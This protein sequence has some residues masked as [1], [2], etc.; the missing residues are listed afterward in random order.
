MRILQNKIVMSKVNNKR[1]ENQSYSYTKLWKSIKK[2]EIN[3]VLILPGKHQILFEATDGLYGNSVIEMDD[4]L[5][6]NMIEHN[7]DINYNFDDGIDYVNFIPAILPLAFFLIVMRMLP[8]NNVLPQQNEKKKIEI[9]KETNVKFENVAGIDEA[10]SEIVE[11]VDFLKDP[12]KYE[13]AGAVIP[14]GCLI[15]GPPGTG[16]TL[17]AKAIAGEANVPFISSSASEFVEIF[18]GMG[19]LRIRE[20]FIKARKNAPCIVFIDEIDAIGKSRSLNPATSNDEREQTLNQLL[21]EMDGFENNSGVIIIAATNRDE[22]LDKALVRPGRFDRKINISLPTKSGRLEI[23]NI[24]SKNKKVKQTDLEILA[25][26]TIGFS[27]AELMN[28]MN[29]SSI[30]AAR[31]N[32]INITKNDIDEAYDKVTLGLK[33]PHILSKRRKEMIAY[34][35]AGHALLALLCENYD[36]VER[37]TIIPR[38]NA[39]GVTQ[40][41]PNEEAMNSGMYSNEYLRN[42][43]LVGLGGRLAEAFIYGSDEMTTGATNDLQIVTQIARTMVEKYGFSTNIGMVEINGNESESMKRKIDEE[44]SKLIDENYE[45]GR[46]LLLEHEPKLT[47]IAK[48]LLKQETIYEDELKKILNEYKK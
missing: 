20:M 8:M 26:K 44:V 2:N 9:I 4:K 41:I 19:A 39:G 14:R 33:R 1:I 40:F 29:E 7:V 5:M 25:N 42:K 32:R 3:K 37:V 38:G 34:H 13:N 23:L 47:K 21:T 43:I 10:K 45:K 28:I 11:L 18:V 31:S 24:H 17:M 6:E 36:R 27:G 12:T 16:K 35:E 48:L 30:M 15:S 22:I 46:M